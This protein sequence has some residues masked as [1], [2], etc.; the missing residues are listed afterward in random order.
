M[1][2]TPPWWARDL[3]IALLAGLTLLGIQSI[4][5]ER[6]ERST[7]RLENVRFVRER[8]SPVTTDRPFAGMDLAHQNLRGLFLS[9]ADFRGANLSGADLS[10]ANLIGAKFGNANLQSA[11]FVGADLSDAKF[12][13][14]NL[15]STKFVRANLTTARFGS[16]RIDAATDFSLATLTSARFSRTDLSHADFT[17]LDE[18]QLPQADPNASREG[19]IA[20]SDNGPIWPKGFD[21]PWPSVIVQDYCF[22]LRRPKKE[23]FTSYEWS[24]VEQFRGKPSSVDPV[25]RPDWNE[26]AAYLRERPGVWIKVENAARF[27]EKIQRR[28]IPWFAVGVWD[29]LVNRNTMYAGADTTSLYI[30]YVGAY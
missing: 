26:I 14:T 12:V 10:G 7:R 9:G 21:V 2:R 6:R 3:L 24:V 13:N 4:L 19:F 29:V 17:G 11:K 8:A 28:E 30:R 22:T 5:D 27:R 20:C 16:A 23:E 1:A 15:K 18:D 25:D